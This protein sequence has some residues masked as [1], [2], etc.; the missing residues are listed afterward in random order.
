MFR[1]VT[2]GSV[3]IT[4][5]LSGKAGV[6]NLTLDRHVRDVDEVQKLAQAYSLRLRNE[7]DPFPDRVCHS[8]QRFTAL[9]PRSRSQNLIFFRAVD[10]L[11]FL[12]N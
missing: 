1:V 2:S 5:E 4:I 11:N 7:N 10:L 9:I 3:Q 6:H 12:A 8:V